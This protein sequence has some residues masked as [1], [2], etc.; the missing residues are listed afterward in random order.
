MLGFYGKYR[1]LQIPMTEFI[2]DYELE[3]RY[4]CRLDRIHF[5]WFY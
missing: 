3:E 2:I 1:Y 5:C 4:R